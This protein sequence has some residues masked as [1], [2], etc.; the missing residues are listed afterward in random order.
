VRLVVFDDFRVGVTDRE[1]IADVTSVLPR[2]LDEWPEQRMNWLIRNW[3][4]VA[5]DLQ[6]V[7]LRAPSLPLD[8]ALLRAINP[9]AQHVL[10]LPANYAAHI[11]ELGERSVTIRRSAR[12]QGFFLKA[13]GSLVGAGESIEIPRSSRRRFDHECELAVVIGSEAR[14]VPRT[15]A[16]HYIFGYSCLIDVTMRIEP[17]EHEEDR[18]MR[19][20]FSSFTPVGPAL[21]TVDEISDIGDL[22]S[23]LWVNGEIRQQAKL[24][25]MIV[26][27]EEAIE[28][29]SSVL[30][31]LPG[32]IV[33]MGTPAGVGPII[34]GDR[35]RIEITEIGSM[36]LP[37]REGAAPLAGD[38]RLTR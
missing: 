11:G 38:F 13:P 24:H 36:E 21:V 8:K 26:G 2:W 31:L 35:V 22:T 37:V 4:A 27:V 12:D 34:S 18:S 1:A 17:G 6:E 28:L 30:P 3:S 19:K 14:H 7:A 25:E 9:G 32:D 33:A 10:A 5:G 15:E 29:I 23:R 16:R 20:S